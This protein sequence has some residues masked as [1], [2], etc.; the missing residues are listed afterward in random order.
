MM[1]DDNKEL[2][3]RVIR[4]SEMFAEHR[5]SDAARSGE[6][7]HAVFQAIFPPDSACYASHEGTSVHENG[8]FYG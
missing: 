4:V 7:E 1:E 8:C 6:P 3:G 2:Q 5:S